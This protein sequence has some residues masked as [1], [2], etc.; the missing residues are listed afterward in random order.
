[1]KSSY[2]AQ[3]IKNINIITVLNGYANEDILNHKISSFV[4]VIS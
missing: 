2:K 4:Y 3:S 1:M